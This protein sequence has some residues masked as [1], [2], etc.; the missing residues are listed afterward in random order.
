VGVVLG[1]S[2]ELATVPWVFRK[3]KSG[4]AHSSEFSR[5]YHDGEMICQEGELSAEMFVVQRGGVRI[6][7]A[8]QHAPVEL[9]F[10]EKGDFF[11][12]M[13]VLEDL[14]RD[15]SAQAVGETEVLV[16]STGAL[17]IRLR[18]DPT[19]AFELLRRLS[20]RV[21]GLNARLMAAL[22]RASPSMQRTLQASEAES[23]LYYPEDKAGAEALPVPPLVGRAAASQLPS[24]E[25][26]DGLSPA[27][28]AP[29]NSPSARSDAMPDRTL[30]SPVRKG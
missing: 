22:E 27:S 30:Q 8:A 11:G 1:F 20:G 29:Q 7:K 12:E 23:M 26:S 17:L 25:P 28:P 16:M 18:R 24:S 9:A 6:Y 5:T 21:R 14:P 13:S 3:R 2:T 15:A 4:P 19:F 10:L